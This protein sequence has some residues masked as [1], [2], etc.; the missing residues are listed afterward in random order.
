MKVGLIARAEQRG[1]GVMTSA[2]YRNVR[3]AK[4][5]IVDMAQLA[6]GFPNDFAQYGPDA[7]RVRYSPDG[8]LD[9]DAVR[10]W[11]EGL[12]VVYSAETF[13]DARLPVWAAEAGVA[14][15]LAPMPEFFRPDLNER[16]TALWN[17]TCW[18]HDTL[19]ERATIVPVPVEPAP[20]EW[21][22]GDGPLRV[23]HVAG[24]KAAM[25]RNGTNILAT[26]LPLVHRPMRVT[27]WCQ[28]R[29][30]PAIR[31]RRNV[32]LDVRLGGVGDR[33]E[34]YRDADLFVLPRR[35]GGLSLVANEAAAAGLGLVLTD[36]EP[37]RDMP[38]E[39]IPAA[40]GGELQ[41]PGGSVRL[42]NAD[43]RKLA[44]LL[45]ELAGDAERVAAMRA[46]SR[47]WA[48]GLSWGR[49]RAVYTDGLAG[50]ARL[51]SPR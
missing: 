10:G 18:R 4:T 33:W 51:A 8:T 6:R 28:D 17:P 2:F 50:A 36:C 19:P 13:Y 46:A 9:G 3:P 25:D 12:D 37:N 24:H 45:D 30:L 5:L 26:A 39:L 16:T 20:H 49:L 47:A 43:P 38:A 34:M 41:T 42:H 40:E 44:A 7:T 11:L 32:D 27:V 22:A 1:L 35:Y 21:T 23:V 48:D 29:R 15:V 14:T 31:A